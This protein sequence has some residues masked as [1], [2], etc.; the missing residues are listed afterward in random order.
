MLPQ[1]LF[2]QNKFY[3]IFYQSFEFPKTNF[4]S[5]ERQSLIHQMLMT[6][7]QEALQESH[8]NISDLTGN[9]LIL[10]AVP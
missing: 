6:K 2:L 5:L 8:S 3:E 7:L 1:N 10:N 9:L 4:R